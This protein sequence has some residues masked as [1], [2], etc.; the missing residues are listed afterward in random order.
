MIRHITTAISVLVAGCAG[1][2]E[3]ISSELTRSGLDPGQSRCIGDRLSAN[4]SLGE[5]RQLGRAARAYQ[6]VSK[7][8][9]GLSVSDLVYVAAQFDD[10][11]VPLV[12]GLAI[13]GCGVLE[14]PRGP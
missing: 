9:G 4:L 3:Q 10:A 7:T 2:S 11:R 8:P 13:V 1:T 14:A 12:V 5:L 6:Q